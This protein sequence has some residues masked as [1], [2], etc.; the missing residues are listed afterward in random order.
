LVEGE[1]EKEEDKDLM[2]ESLWDDEAKL[3]SRCTGH[4]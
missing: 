4:C 1:E 2:F 3:L